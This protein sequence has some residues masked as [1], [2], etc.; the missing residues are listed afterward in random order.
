MHID[1][2][3]LFPD[4][5]RTVSE[6]SILGRAQ[7]NQLITVNSVDIRSFSEDR[8]RKTD[9][10]PYGG[11][12]GMVM[13]PQPIFDALRSV[14]AASKRV[15]YLSP[16]GRILDQELTEELAKESD[17]VF[18]C[19]HYE[20]VDQRILDYWHADEISIGDYILTGG[21]LAALVVIDAVSRLVPGVLGNEASAM[22]E[23]IYS[24]L[25]ECPQYTRPRV[26][27]GS[28]VPEV[29]LSG[30][31][32]K[33]ELWRYEQSL[34]ETRERRPDLWNEYLGRA[35]QLELSKKQLEILADCSGEER[36]RPKRRKKRKKKQTDQDHEIR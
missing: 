1:I 8:H 36:F 19:G 29:L 18:L 2:L 4:M 6:Y 35:G 9:E 21:E 11:G 23:S 5:I 31:H 20:G 27:E 32:E 26:Y 14:D 17:L 12:E 24:G 25:L 22:S 15:I 7:A 33:I 3:T 28:E 10:A 34:K 13:T 16:K 30:D